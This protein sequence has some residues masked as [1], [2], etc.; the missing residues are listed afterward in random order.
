M[1]SAPAKG[2]L[3]DKHKIAIVVGKKKGSR[4]SDL[5]LLCNFMSPFSVEISW[6]MLAQDMPIEKNIQRMRFRLWRVIE[7]L[8]NFLDSITKKARIQIAFHVFELENSSKKFP[9]VP[10]FIH[11]F[12]ER[13]IGI[14]IQGPVL[15]V[16]FINQSVERYSKWYPHSPIVLSTW[17]N[18]VRLPEIKEIPNLT[19]VVNTQPNNPGISNLNYQAKSTLSGI[20]RLDELQCNYI[21]KSRTDQTF[22]NDRAL[23]V[24]FSRLENSPKGY[25]KRI[26]TTD[27]NSF[28]FRPYSPNDQLMFGETET[29][30][31]FW[32]SYFD[33]ANF[34]IID[35]ESD[36]AEKLLLRSYLGSLG[37]TFEATHRQSLSIYRDLYSFVDHEDLDLFWKK[38][39]HRTLRSRFPQTNFPS[40]NSFVRYFDWESLQRDLNPYLVLFKEVDSDFHP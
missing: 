28:L 3:E 38:G 9:I 8:F 31:R 35:S 17:E 20:N 16:G 13:K 18:E 27:F 33:R 21:L 32:N 10:N 40:T 2:N 30:S 11:D 26:V 25:F 37:I 7:F 24:L 39:T 12:S 22:F 15:D 4:R 1:S 34:G 5:I 29:I 23:E 6:A 14:L 36:F 19:V